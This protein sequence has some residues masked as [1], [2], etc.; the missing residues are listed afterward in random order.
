[1]A[2]SQRSDNE[3]ILLLVGAIVLVSQDAERYLKFTLPF[4]KSEDPSLG[5]ALKRAEKLRKRTLGELTGR[6]V[7]ASTSNSVDF[8]Q[9]MAYLVA[10]RNQVVHHF[11]ET[12][13]AQVS[14][15][16]HQDV[17]DALETLLANLKSYRT[18]LE[19]IALT[20]LEGL[21]DVTFR[22]TP[23][24]SEISELCASFRSQVAS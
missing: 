5:A 14:S 23:E 4:V 6:F 8:A 10:A 18:G 7:D 2:T 11:N 13:G 19:Q 15:G 24:Y 3:K 20:V 1:M 9:H 16:A 21:R 22:D 17:L 12:Y